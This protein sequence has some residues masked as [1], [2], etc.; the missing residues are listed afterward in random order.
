MTPEPGVLVSGGTPPNFSRW[1][2]P[3]ATASQPRRRAQS[4]CGGGSAPSGAGTRVSQPRGPGR[5]PRFLPLPPAALGS[6]QVKRRC[7]SGCRCRC[8]YHRRPAGSAS[9]PNAVIR[10]DA[11]SLAAASRHEPPPSRPRPL[12]P[13]PRPQPRLPVTP[14]SR[15][16]TPQGGEPGYRLQTGRLAPR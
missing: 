5:A 16:V 11:A 14:P 4:S 8:R 10:L 3:A 13:R 7:R 9:Q 15:H 6:G 12:S 1:R 2:Q